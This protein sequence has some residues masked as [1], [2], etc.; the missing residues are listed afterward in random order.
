MRRQLTSRDAE[1]LGGCGEV[2]SCARPPKPCQPEE[3][4]SKAT[5]L[6]AAA[7]LPFSLYPKVTSIQWCSMLD[8]LCDSRAALHHTHA[9]RQ[10][11]RHGT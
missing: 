8:T 10:M 6:A 4:P 11:L 3:S 7:A 5:F 1:A 9:W 2:K